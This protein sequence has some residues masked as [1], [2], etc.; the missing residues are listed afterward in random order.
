M[1]SFYLLLFPKVKG[2]RENTSYLHP[3]YPDSTTKLDMKDKLD[4]IGCWF[5]IGSTAAGG[6]ILLSFPT[7]QVVDVQPQS[8]SAIKRTSGPYRS[9]F[10]SAGYANNPRMPN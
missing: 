2:E 7:L 5:Q 10:S 3:L 4:T 6:G 8:G 1:K 9:S